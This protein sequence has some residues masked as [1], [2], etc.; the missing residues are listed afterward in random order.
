MQAPIEVS[1]KSSGEVFVLDILSN[2]MSVMAIL[3]Q[4]SYELAV[5]ER[6]WFSLNIA[7]NV[8]PTK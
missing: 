1:R 7:I 2:R 3:R 4:Q 6:C 8:S 5:A